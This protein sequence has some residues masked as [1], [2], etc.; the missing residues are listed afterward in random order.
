[1]YGR[2]F[3]PILVLF[4]T[5]T[6]A[7]AAQPRTLRINERIDVAGVSRRFTV[8]LPNACKNTTSVPLVIVLHGALG[9]GW[10]A[11]FDSQMTRKAEKEHFIVVYPNG[12]GRMHR[13]FL[14]WNVG[15]CCG[16]ASHKHANDVGFIRQMIIALTKEY[17]IDPNRIYVTG[18]SNG[19]ML[20]YRVAAEMPDLVAAIC[21]IS[22]CMYAIS[23]EM[24]APVSVVAFHGT[25]DRVIPYEGG[26]GCF[27]GY[28]VRTRPVAEAIQYWVK[29]NGC[30]SVPLREQLD[31]ASKDTYTGGLGNTEVCLY[32]LKKGGHCWPGG[33]SAFLLADRPDTN[34][35]AT[36]LMWQFFS[37]HPKQY[38]ADKL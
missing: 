36:D 27:F 31:A 2:I 19:G 34:L 23:G 11:E 12:T 18:L 25:R 24:T 35:S 10:S 7:L 28:P 21:P 4:V 22:A 15:P 1:M 8:C 26:L 30:N 29:R 3:I 17:Q 32:T 9:N 14:T 38:L 33:R 13:Y 20:A 6:Q 5:V 37:S 16:T